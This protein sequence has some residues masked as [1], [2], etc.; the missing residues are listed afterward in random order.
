[1]PAWVTI[2]DAIAERFVAHP[3]NRLD[4]CNAVLDAM[5]LAATPPADTQVPSEP[6]TE[7]VGGVNVPDGSGRTTSID[8]NKLERIAKERPDEYFLRG[9][10]VLKLLGAIRLLE[11]ELRALRT[12]AAPEAGAQVPSDVW[13]NFPCYLIDHCEGETITE[14]GLQRALA[15]MLKDP[16]YRRDA[17]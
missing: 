2:A 11:A 10:G 7:F 17:K 5:R 14:E 1:M 8:A 9:T 15:A 3:D 6:Y 4:L 16:K 13:A 12:P